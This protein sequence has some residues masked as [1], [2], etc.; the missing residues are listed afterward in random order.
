MAA[1]KES[2]HKFIS[3]QEL[4]LTENAAPLE[5]KAQE[6]K[7]RIKLNRE[8]VNQDA[9]AHIKEY[10]DALYKLTIAERLVREGRL[11][12][13]EVETYFRN[14]LKDKFNQE[15]FDNAWFVIA[16]YILEGGKRTH[17]GTGLPK[18]EEQ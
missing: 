6:Y 16:N 4:F 3:P 1:E 13:Q 9:A 11:N 7:Q 17:G 12:K 10:F 18:I 5:A 15:L 2:W 8:S 14:E